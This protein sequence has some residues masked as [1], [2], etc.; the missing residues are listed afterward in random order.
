MRGTATVNSESSLHQHQQPKYQQPRGDEFESLCDVIAQDAHQP[1]VSEELR[2]EL[3][4]ERGSLVVEDYVRKEVAMC[5]A[6]IAYV[7]SI[8][9]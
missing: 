5:T 6:F 3:K 7:C 8:T 4:T 1:E 9:R 2:I